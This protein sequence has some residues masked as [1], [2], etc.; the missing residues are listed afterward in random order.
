MSLRKSLYK[1]YSRNSASTTSFLNFVDQGTGERHWIRDWY[2]PPK[3]SKD[4]NLLPK[5]GTVL[6]RHASGLIT[7]L[8][9]T[10]Q[11]QSSISQ[12][13]T[14]QP[15]ETYG[16]KVKTWILS[17]Q[18]VERKECEDEE[19]DTII[20]LAQNRYMDED[21]ASER[22]EGGSGLTEAEMKSAVGGAGVS[23]SLFSSSLAQELKVKNNGDANGSETAEVE[24]NADNVPEDAPEDSTTI[25]TPASTV[26]PGTD[27]YGDVVMQ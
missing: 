14:P 3:I 9:A 10:P 16:F 12:S 5:Q 18:Q 19:N 17:D 24:P 8:E 26:Q 15:V 23:N 6:T 27:A 21:G 22:N 11:P 20:A 7:P 2:D 25:V 1:H 4:T 13:Q